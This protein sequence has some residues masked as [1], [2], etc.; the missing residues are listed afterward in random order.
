MP[1]DQRFDILFE[2]QKIG[3]VTAPNRFYQVP[4]CTGMGYRLPQ[5][6]A[7]LRRTKAEGGWGVVNTE[8]CSI[9]PTSDDMPYP[10]ASLWDDGDVRNLARIA[11]DIHAHG[12]LAGVELWHGGLRSSNLHTREPAIGPVS[13]PAFGEP[14]QCRAME[15]DDITA[16]RAW[17]RAAARRAVTAG[18]DIVYVYAAHTYLLAQFLDPL[19]NQRRDAYGGSAEN[20]WRL[21][22]EIVEDTREAVAGKAAVALRIEVVD[23]DGDGEAERTEMLASLAP[24]VDL[25]DVT[26]PDYSH[27]MGTSRFIREGS[28]ADK[29]RHVRQ[30]TAKPV[31][32]VGRFTTPET[33]LA[34]V[35]G[36]VV[37][38]IG[39]ARPSIADPFL[40]QKI[41]DDRQDDI[42]ECIGCNI[43]YASD[44]RGVPIRC[45]Q[46]PT[47]GEEWRRG[48]HPESV[49]PARRPARALIVGS[50]PAGLEAAHILG[51]RGVEV[52]LAEAEE[53][54]GGRV[55]RESRLPGF[56][57][58]MRVA[59]YRINQLAK[60]G[61]VTVYRA[62][63]MTAGDVVDTG[64][65]HV[66]V[67]TGSRWR[68]DGRGRL[69]RTPVPS[70]ADERVIGVDAILDGAR[71]EGPVV[72]ADD[73]NFYMASAIAEALAGAG[74]EVAYVA[75][76]S[77]VASWAVH[78]YDQARIHAALDRL[79]ITIILNHRVTELMD[80]TAVLTC[81][82]TGRTREIAC[83]TLVPVTS[84]E[85]EASL[86]HAL[87]AQHGAR[88]ETL[89]RIGDCAAPGLIA[90]AVHDGHRAAREF[91]M[92]AGD[93]VARR[94]RV[95]L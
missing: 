15:A 22:R 8:Y 3:P 55:R 38:F 43:C 31:V 89:I 57:E 11:A 16:L 2:P 83:R 85:P 80:G 56:S 65:A 74:R 10:H 79:G 4:H 69:R 48:W 66:F 68:T 21:V 47:M 88:F 67:A 20:R 58:W 25:Y 12:A 62:S 86:W 34:M 39:A 93:G 44:S 7:H 1:R 71:P 76:D 33:M 24:M 52:V 59:D 61:G 35:K 92:E 18:F 37:D 17:H 94:D 75:S 41:R 14:W 28:L 45:T 91:D 32:S 50:G 5:M 27:E 51:K 46:N 87:R 13:H 81:M 70:F 77:L 60:L 95:V 19:V 40:P 73:D 23:E 53:E 90:H 82:F 29:I 36:G 54:L 72:V 30:A 64:I 42:R 84:R 78:T 9:H 49:P 63:R 6:L 26:V